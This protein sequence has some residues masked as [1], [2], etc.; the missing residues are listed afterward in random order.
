MEN[1]PPLILSPDSLLQ[2]SP[3]Y[4]FWNTSLAGPQRSPTN[5]SLVTASKE[6]TE[7]KTQP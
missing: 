5:M 4:K 7:N 6:A 2:S 3:K 1:R